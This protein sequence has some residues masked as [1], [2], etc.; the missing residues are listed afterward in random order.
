MKLTAELKV[1]QAR[2]SLLDSPTDRGNLPE[3]VLILRVCRTQG[4]KFKMYQETG[5][6]KPHLHIDYGKCHHA[7]SFSI[8]PAEKLAGSLP[9]KHSK[10]VIG[11]VNENQEKLLELWAK[12]QEGKEVGPL[13]ESLSGNT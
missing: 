2:L 3:D 11:W 12:L 13:V 8:N 4:L 10:I 9:A 1:L 7:A 5:H 6:G